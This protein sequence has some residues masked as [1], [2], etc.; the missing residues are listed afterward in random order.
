MVSIQL[1]VTDKD[2]QTDMDS[3]DVKIGCPVDIW[4][5]ALLPPW[6]DKGRVPNPAP[7]LTSPEIGY[8]DYHEFGTDKRNVPEKG[9][10]A[11]Q[12]S[13]IMVDLCNPDQPVVKELHGIGVSEGFRMQLQQ[14]GKLSE[15]EDLARA[16]AQKMK[17]E[18]IKTGDN[19][20]KVTLVGATP[21]SFHKKSGP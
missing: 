2:G 3:I 4:V 18:A 12:W 1:K 19:Q 14:D 7:I 6:T 21:Y 8:I 13:Y 17:E 15:A 9:G 11:R 5:S 10:S 16:G 20:I